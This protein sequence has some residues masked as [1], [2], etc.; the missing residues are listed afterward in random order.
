MTLSRAA[1][2]RLLMGESVAVKH[3][4]VMGEVPIALLTKHMRGLSKLH[5]SGKGMYVMKISTSHAKYLGEKYGQGFWGD[6]WNGIKKVGKTIAKVATHPLTKAAVKEV[7]NLKPVAQRLDAA[8]K[9]VN[10]QAPGLRLGDVGRKALKDYTGGRV[11]VMKAKK[12]K[13]VLGSI[14]NLLD[15]FF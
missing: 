8:Q 2:K 14:G 9:F 6:L 12:G 15:E 10:E 5:Q 4:Q 13:G 1:A 7:S 3:S 11:K